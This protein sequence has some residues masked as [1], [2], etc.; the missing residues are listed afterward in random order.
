MAGG[1]LIFCVTINKLYVSRRERGG[2][3]SGNRENLKVEY[4]FEY[5]YLMINN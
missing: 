4:S 5:K 3:S 1:K 2:Q